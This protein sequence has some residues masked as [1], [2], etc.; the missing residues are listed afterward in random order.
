[1]VDLWVRHKVRNFD[2]WKIIFDNHFAMR[3]AGGEASCRV[4]YNA[5]NATD[6]VLF[7]E[8]NSR[9]AAEAFHASPQ[10]RKGMEEAGVIGDVEI[11]FVSEA[12]QLRRTAAD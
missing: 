1:M 2:E 5:D 12:R 11:I 4:F 8:W 7:F 10:A 9:A 3:K 6:I